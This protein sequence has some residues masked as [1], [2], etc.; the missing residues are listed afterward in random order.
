VALM[1]RTF[2]S[3]GRSFGLTNM[4]IDGG[5]FM[6]FTGGATLWS[7]SEVDPT[8]EPLKRQW[9]LEHNRAYLRK[10][11]ELQRTFQI[12]LLSQI[13]GY[14]PVGERASWK[15]KYDEALLA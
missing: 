13:E 14:V 9:I 4:V 8:I 12:G 10:M 11:A 5:V 2:P 7:L 6:L 1:Q 15:V 3:Y